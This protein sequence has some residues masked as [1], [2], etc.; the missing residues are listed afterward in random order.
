MNPRQL[1][2][3]GALAASLAVPAAA[4]A[5]QT[6]T[7][8]V[9]RQ[10]EE[11]LGRDVSQEEIVE[12]L[13]RSGLTRSQVRARLQAMG[14]D[15]SIADPYFNAMRREGEPPE[16]EPSRRLLEAIERLG[17]MEV[18]DSLMALLPDSLRDQRI[19]RD[20]LLAVLDSILSDS[21]AIDSIREGRLPIFGMSLFEGA[22]NQF[23]PTSFGPVGPG[24]RI[25]PGDELVL[26]LTGGVEA[27]YDLTVTREGFVVIP[28]VGQVQVSGLTLSE[29]E[30]RLY[31]RLGRVFSGVRRGPEATIRF[32]LSLGE[33]RTHQVYLVGDVQRPGAYQVGAAS[34]PFNALYQAG[35]PGPMGSFRR[36]EVR[37][38]GRLVDA[39]D[40]YDY[41]LTGGT[42]EDVQLQDGDRVFVP[43]VGTRVAVDGEIRRP[44]RYE[45]LSGETVRDLI[46]FAG[47]FRAQA[48]VRRIQIDRILPVDERRPG[49]DRVLV[50]VPLDALRPG[51]PSIELRDGDEVTVF[52]VSEERRNRVALRGEVNR[53]GRYQWTPGMTLLD[54]I[55]RAE[56][57][58]ESA[59]TQ[60]AQV[61]R[62]NPA[63]GTRTLIPAAL[64]FGTEGETS[65]RDLRLADRDSVVIFSRAEMSAVDSVGIMGFVKEPGTFPYAEGM[66]AEDLVLAAGGFSPGANTLQAELARMPPSAARSD[67]AAAVYR[68]PL[69][70]GVDSD[71]PQPRLQPGDRVFIRQAPGYAPVRSVVITGEV[72]NPGTY[73]LGGRD[74]RLAELIARTG[75]LSSEAYGQGTQLV[76]DSARVGIDLT[77][78]LRNPRG[79]ASVP[80]MDGDSIHVPT[81]DPTVTVSGAVQFATQ[82]AYMPGQDLA[83]YIEMAGGYAPDADPKRVSVTYQNGER[84]ML[85]RRT[86]FRVSPEPR[87]GSEIFVPAVPPELREGVDWGMVFSRGVTALGTLATLLLALDRVNQ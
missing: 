9:R 22:R 44:A 24:Y 19:P 83:Y 45:M 84:E 35:G 48:V 69:H 61:F 58:A 72:R 33:L 1:L 57:L 20:S 75:G 38:G 70:L 21:V 28:D 43:V 5:Q 6:D 63:D 79:P 73:P 53:P 29:L 37:R 26:I 77:R 2:A 18:P 76:R 39:V 80:L 4:A 51:G 50:D 64:E 67:T 13:R 11:R 71:A 85:S 15:P 49:V 60:R 8:A 41:L 81:Y 66:T 12:R 52:A 36:V 82:V 55:D 34:T 7:A 86:M 31:D 3:I 30:D 74:E 14:Y 42:R 78:A 40:L 56:G 23:Q 59:Y 27:A 65:G 87:P 32:Q 17:I 46:A 16:G 10:A 25:G 68:V 62:L 47:G 54:L